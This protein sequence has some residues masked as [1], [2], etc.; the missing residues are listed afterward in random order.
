MRTIDDLL[1]PLLGL[2][3]RPAPFAGPLRD[4]LRDVVTRLD[5]HLDQ[6]AAQAPTDLYLRGQDLIGRLRTVCRVPGRGVHQA[7]LAE[8]DDA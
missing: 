7:I 1:E 6:R 5:T 2:D 3:G 8:L 4:L